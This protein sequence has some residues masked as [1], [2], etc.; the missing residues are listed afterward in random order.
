[1]TPRRAELTQRLPEWEQ[2]AAAAAASAISSSIA[3][4]LPAAAPA[5]APAAAPVVV[6]ELKRG[7]ADLKTHLQV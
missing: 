2:A 5:P 1:M 6:S 7:A 4:Q 3:A